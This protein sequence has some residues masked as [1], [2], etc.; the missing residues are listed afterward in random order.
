MHTALLTSLRLAAFTILAAV[1]CTPAATEP[2]GAELP[3]APDTDAR[4]QALGILNLARPAPGLLTAGQLDE[5]QFLAL[6]E[7]GYA[8][9]I[10]LRP[11]DEAGTGWEEALAEAR[12]I[13]FRRLPVAGAAGVTREN[14]Q[15]LATELETASAD[16]V[17]IYCA[18]GNR[19][20][21][22]LALK[23]HHLDGL[24]VEA[25]LAFGRAAGMTRLEPKVR[26]LLGEAR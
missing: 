12:G 19:V 21:A 1:A 8:T 10:N 5:A 25:A 14:A 22:L 9:L 24:D 7:L 23:A 17:V 2:R 13:D 20:G 26:A 6:V 15:R 3:G 16:G 11:A 4:A 18:S